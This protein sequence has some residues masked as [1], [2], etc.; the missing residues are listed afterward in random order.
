MNTKTAAFAVALAIS[1]SPLAWTNAANATGFG[2]R[3]QL[4][5]GT[6]AVTGTDTC[7]YTV[8]GFNEDLTPKKR[9][10]HHPSEKRAGYGSL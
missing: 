1:V 7:I 9:C 5:R 4:L 3:D 10:D 6:F 2:D 8:E